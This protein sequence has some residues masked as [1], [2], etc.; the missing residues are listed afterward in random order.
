MECG[1][2]PTVHEVQDEAQLVGGVEGVRHAH[3]ERAVLQTQR[4]RESKYK[5]K[6]VE[7]LQYD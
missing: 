3:D 4:V 7:I 5:Y 1:G 2:H 6:K